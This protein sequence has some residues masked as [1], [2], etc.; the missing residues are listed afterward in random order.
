MLGD[1]SSLSSLTGFGSFG[2]VLW[3]PLDGVR[4]VFM[5]V[6]DLGG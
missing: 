2:S 5:V 4:E 6:G 1:M 3:A